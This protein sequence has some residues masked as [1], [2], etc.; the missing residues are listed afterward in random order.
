MSAYIRGI[1][2]YFPEPVRKN[3][4][5]PADF[6][7]N[8]AARGDR[9]F[10]DIARA[11]D[12][13]RAV[14]ERYLEQEARDPF[15][16]CRERRVAPDSLCSADAEIS[17]ALAALV[18]GE[19]ASSEID[20]VISYSVT[21]DRMTPPSAARVAEAL[22]LARAHAF[23]IDSA[24][25]SALVQLELARALVRSGQAR[26]VLLTQSHL[27]LR[28][29]PMLHPAAPGLGDAATAL[30]VGQRGRWEILETHQVTHGRFYDAVTW[31]RGER[32][33][34]NRPWYRAGGDF[35]VGSLDRAGAK[36]LQR[37]TVS[38]SA[39]T[40]RE[41]CDKARR[42]A[43]DI[44]LLASVEPRGWVPKAT[45]ELLGLPLA[46]CSSVY[47]TR[48]HLGACG[49]IANLDHAYRARR[50]EGARLCALYAQG[51]GF[52]RAG[53]LLAMNA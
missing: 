26:N 27:L 51:A 21:P 10:N 2:T 46:V 50:T 37:D 12:A 22:G 6:G 16:G 13:A 42:S 11:E 53:A 40:L 48:G 45:A 17:A 14:T 23:S 34:D 3:H 24:C 32:G 47:E 1:A 41:L 31:V 33:D 52:T 5:W 7:A 29:F 36:A 44:D 39:L 28:S 25:A 4:E 49:P 38:F 18:D 19:V 8:L 20:V 15:L 9:L 30:V 35:Q 43:R